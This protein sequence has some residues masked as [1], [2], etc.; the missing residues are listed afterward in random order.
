MF[1]LKS[2]EM[3]LDFYYMV[4]GTAKSPRSLRSRPPFQ[5][6]IGILIFFFV[7]LTKAYIRI[8]RA[9]GEKPDAA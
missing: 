7:E 5:V 1:L 6:G 3:A 2:R 8:S 9:D 4:M